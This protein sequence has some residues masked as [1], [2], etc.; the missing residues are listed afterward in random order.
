V[1][2]NDQRNNENNKDS[3][4]QTK[5]DALLP[6]DLNLIVQGQLTYIVSFEYTKGLYIGSYYVDN[7]NFYEF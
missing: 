5:L 6:F 7:D 4:T 2:H 1:I 3:S